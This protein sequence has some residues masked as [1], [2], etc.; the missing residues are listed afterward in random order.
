MYCTPSGL[1]SFGP[2]H[3]VGARKTIHSRAFITGRDFVVDEFW[4]IS[5]VCRVQKSLNPSLTGGIEAILYD[6]L[7][8]CLAFLTQY[9]LS[10][11]SPDSAFELVD[12]LLANAQNTVHITCESI[13][14]RILGST[15]RNKKQVVNPNLCDIICCFTI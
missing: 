4:S 3:S 15:E 11:S 10:V 12:I 14:I 13:Y 1:R 9:Q 6:F 7:L 8:I 5:S 2:P